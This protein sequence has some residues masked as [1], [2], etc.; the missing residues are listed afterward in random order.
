M[1]RDDAWGAFRFPS[2]GSGGQGEVG[3]QGAGP[4]RK[5]G[6][7]GECLLEVTHKRLPSTAPLCHSV[8]HRVRDGS[9]D[10]S[11]DTQ[12]YRDERTGATERRSE[13]GTEQRAHGQC[14]RSEGQGGPPRPGPRPRSQ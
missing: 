5:L 11:P 9:H 1:L 3:V 6:F 4:L 14:W 10:R 2:T 12:N 7:H 13:V 8:T